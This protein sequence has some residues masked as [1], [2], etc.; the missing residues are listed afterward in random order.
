M[1][2]NRPQVRA[3]DIEGTAD[4]LS[5]QCTTVS[6]IEKEVP[7]L[8]RA[9]RRWYTERADS[10]DLVQ[11]TLERALA[12]A[13]LWEPGS[14]L[15]GWLFTVMRNCFLL[16]IK[17]CRRRAVAL[18]LLGSRL[19]PPPANGPIE[20]LTV[21]DLARAF[22]RLTP[23]QRTAIA[24]TSINGESYESAAQIMKVSTAAVRAH[25]ARG[26]ECLRQAVF[27]G[28]TTSP[29]WPRTSR[30]TQ[31]RSRAAVAVQSIPRGCSL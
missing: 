28:S 7:F 1:Q 2:V 10:E 29:L 8:R 4:A 18:A 24:L 30:G 16:N 17:K 6:L 3:D 31:G 12:S 21:R 22:H 27:A 14:N 13:H 11:D 25:L 15:R 23:R 19:A 5:G 26:R 9:A 20:R